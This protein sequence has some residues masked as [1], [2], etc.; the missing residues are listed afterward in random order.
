MY[1]EIYAEDAAPWVKTLRSLGF[2]IGTP[3]RPTAPGRQ[4]R[5]TVP[6]WGGGAGILVSVP[7]RPGPARGWLD[8]HGDGVAEV[9]IPSTG[10]CAACG[11]AP[12]HPPGTSV[13]LFDVKH[14][15]VDQR[16]I[17]ATPG[18]YTALDHVAIV[19]YDLATAEASYR[20]AFGAEWEPMDPIVIGSE[21]M[22]LGVARIP[23]L[24]VTVVAPSSPQGQLRD[25]LKLHNGP[26]VQH[27]AFRVPDIAQHVAATLEAGYL[28]APFSYYNLLARRKP[29]PADFA[30][31]SGLGILYDRDHD[32]ELRQ[33]FT[34]SPVPPV[35]FEVV[36]RDGAAGFG[37]ANITAL[38]EAKMAEGGS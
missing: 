7:D 3:T 11:S 27:V 25:F 33:I 17:I 12:A 31:L 19:V 32:G 30:D 38:Y 26:G 24:T 8:Y 6:A 21:S 4:D 1:A 5:I 23:G 18:E 15:F 28:P 37:K 9:A 2:T 35:F 13:R 14:V 22:N 34:T 29:L 20:N 10:K 36:Q 16:E